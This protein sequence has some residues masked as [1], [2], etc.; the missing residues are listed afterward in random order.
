MKQ[1]MLFTALILLTAC[2][3]DR[4]Q[5][6]KA[7]AADKASLKVAVMPTLDCLPLYV[8][9]D[10]HFFDSAGIDVRLKPFQAQM[11]CDTALLGGSV[12]AS[13]TDLVRAERLISKGLPLTYIT[14]TD[15]Y[16]QLVA[17]RLARIHQLQQ[18]GDKMIAVSRYSA[19]SLL[20]T[21]AVDS[22]KPKNTVFQVQVNDVGVRL[23]M[24]QN[25]EMDALV[26]TEPQ[27]TV[28]R[29]AKHPVLTDS[30]D[31]DLRL[32]AFVIRTDALTGDRMRQVNTR[33]K[34]CTM[35]P[36]TPSTASA[37]LTTATS[38]GSIAVWTT[39]LSGPS[40]NSVSPMRPSPV[41]KTFSKPARDF[42]FDNVCPILFIRTP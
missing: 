32:G 14:A 5:R 23:H 10:R 34:R 11:D 7:L 16:W 22:A 36:A 21:L 24:L 12:E 38:S 1:I 25:N 31:K 26:F 28:A 3:G 15:A 41:R 17:N 2:G 6:E 20:A 40:P 9:A 13:V 42:K 33:L 37:F 19:T 18:L 29:M 8:A 35:R 30:R 39:R 4:Q 27:A